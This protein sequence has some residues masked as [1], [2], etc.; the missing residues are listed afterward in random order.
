MYDQPGYVNPTAFL[1]RAGRSRA[2][3]VRVLPGDQDLLPYLFYP[4]RCVVFFLFFLLFGGTLFG[5]DSDVVVFYTDR[6]LEVFKRN[7]P[8]KR[9]VRLRWCT[10]KFS[11]ERFCLSL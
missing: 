11:A 8:F 7:G 1:A 3:A 5:M 10:S 2:S 6:L 4:N 9:E